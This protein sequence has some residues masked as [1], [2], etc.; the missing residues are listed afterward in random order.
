MSKTLSSHYFL[1]NGETLLRACTTLRES[2]DDK[3]SFALIT[4]RLYQLYQ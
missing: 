4:D 2:S 3:F 1:R